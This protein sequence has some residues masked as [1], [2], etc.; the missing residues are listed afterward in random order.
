[1]DEC[2][3][4]GN[5]EIHLPDE[6][7]ASFSIFQD[8]T[9]LFGVDFQSEAIALLKSELK[10]ELKSHTDL[11][12]KPCIDFESDYADITSRSANTIFLVAGIINELV[13]QE[14]KIEVSDTARQEVLK[15]LKE[16]KRPRPGKWNVGDVFSLKL[17]DST[18]MFGQIIGTHLTPKSP[19]CAIFEIRQSTEAVSFDELKGSRVISVQNTSGECLNDKTFK[20]LFNTELLADIKQANKSKS[21]GDGNLLCLCNAYYGLEPWNVLYKD[22]YYDEMLLKGV[23]RPQRVILLDKDA[24]NKYRLEHFGIDVNNNYVNK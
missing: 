3:K 7:L 12:P 14:E 4:Y 8:L 5:V 11:K 18:F 19:T 2:V 15:R 9:K 1:M 17:K 16:W 22:T 21:T 24:R 10:S 20:V 13:Q 23:E 6:N